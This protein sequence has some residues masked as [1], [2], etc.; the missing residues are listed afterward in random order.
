MA[1][2]ARAEGSRSHNSTRRSDARLRSR[3]KLGAGGS[4]TGSTEE[5]RMLARDAL[6]NI[7]QR[8]L[9]TGKPDALKGA[10]PVWDRG[11]EKGLATVPRRRPMLQNLGKPFKRCSPAT[12]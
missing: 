8:L 9:E 6:R 4:V 1:L 7:P 10:C 11:V 5:E 12:C 2:P 3:G